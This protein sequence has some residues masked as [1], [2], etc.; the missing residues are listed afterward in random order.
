MKLFWLE[1]KRLTM[2]LTFII[3]TIIVVGFIMVNVSPTIN[4]SLLKSPEPNSAGYGDITS[5]DYRTLKTN[6]LDELSYEHRTNSYVTYPLGFAKTVTLTNKNQHRV[7]ILFQKAKLANNRTA[8]AKELQQVDNLLGGQSSYSPKN[9]QSFGL[10]EMTRKEA[11][12]DYHLI[13][14]K[15]K[16]SGSFAR[17]FA[18]IAGVIMG[19]LPTIV[20]IAY[21]YSDR[22]SKAIPVI[23]AKAMSTFRWLVTRYL[24]TL[25]ALVL[26]VILVGGL[27]TI[28]IALLYQHVQI[29][30][31][32]LFQ[33]TFFWVLPTLMISCAIGFLSDALFENF[34][35]FVFQTGWWLITMIIGARQVQGNYGWLFIPRYNSLHNVAYYYDHLDQLILNRA[36]YALLALVLLGI[37]NAILNLKRG[38]KWHALNLQRI[39][40]FGNSH[41]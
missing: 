14:T 39:H 32:A 30:N 38:G 24:A 26:P 40:L 15:D 22:R 37:T 25:A 18:D 29:N 27:F 21:C 13:V 4:N 9:L 31:F 34:F 33:A 5:T 20:V 8:L 7:D 36:G 28:R 10:R 6:A 17:V 11:L 35:G 2:S 41:K 23:H 1:F 16:R 19:I 12:H 3:Y